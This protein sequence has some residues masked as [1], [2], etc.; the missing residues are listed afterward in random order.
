MASSVRVADSGDTRRVT[1]LTQHYAGQA[2]GE[3]PGATLSEI[4]GAARPALFTVEQFATVQ[5]AFTGP[6]LRNLIFRAQPR[7]STKGEIPGNGL[8][9]CAAVVRIGR[10]VLIHE[11][12]FLE[13]VERQ[14]EVQK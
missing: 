3:R 7:H 5:P 9:E 10:K 1:T 14:N 12:R 2:R 6:A 4:L 11:Q 13:W 8:L